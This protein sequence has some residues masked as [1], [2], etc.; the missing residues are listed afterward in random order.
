MAMDL[1][2]EELEGRPRWDYFDG[3]DHLTTDTI[4]RH[5]IKLTGGR[6][7][8]VEQSGNWVAKTQSRMK[9]KEK[10]VYSQE[11]LDAIHQ[12]CEYFSDYYHHNCAFCVRSRSCVPAGL[13]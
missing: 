9:E 12:V 4:L 5:G 3:F 1:A 6:T 13:N 10:Y 2:Q 8:F 7:K 11:I